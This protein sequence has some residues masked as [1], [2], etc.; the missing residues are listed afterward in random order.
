MFNKFA[1]ESLLVITMLSERLQGKSAGDHH[2][3]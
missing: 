3:Y 2:A 1:H